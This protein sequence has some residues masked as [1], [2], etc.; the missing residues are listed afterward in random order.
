MVAQ[1]LPPADPAIWCLGCRPEAQG[2][3]FMRDDQGIE[4]PRQ[5]G[6]RYWHELL[7][8]VE[9]GEISPALARRI[10]DGMFVPGESG[11]PPRLRWSF[12]C[13]YVAERT[14]DYS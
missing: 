7:E 8:L 2:K 10:M 6:D 12:W 11:K 1:A 4:T 14:G 13:A 5:L 3:D 9:Q